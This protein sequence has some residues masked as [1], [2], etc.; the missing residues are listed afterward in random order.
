MQLQL[1]FDSSPESSSS[2]QRKTRAAAEYYGFSV[3]ATRFLYRLLRASDDSTVSLE[4]FDDVGVEDSSGNRTV[5]QDKAYHRDNPVANRAKPLWNTLSN[6]MEAVRCGHLTLGNTWFEIYTTKM[7]KGKIADS[8]SDA[9]TS[10]D[11]HIA[12]LKARDLLGSQ[13]PSGIKKYV[14]RFFSDENTA[15]QL[16]KAFHLVCDDGSPHAELETQW[17]KQLFVPTELRQDSLLHALGWVKK[18]IDVL[19]EKQQPAQITVQD[20]QA[21]MQSYIRKRDNRTIL[22]SI[23]AEPQS[24]VVREQIPRTYVCQLDLIG[25]DDEEKL[26]A[27]NDFLRASVDRTHWSKEGIIHSSSLDEMERELCSIWRN[28]KRKVE[29]T[30]RD[31][32]KVE[33]GRILYLDCT[34][35]RVDLEGLQ[36]QGH[37]TRGSLH[38]LSDDIK[39]GWHP[40]YKNELLQLRK[41]DRSE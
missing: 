11:A 2:F 17:K 34:R 5:E 30:R 25:C 24:G 28:M 15:C 40:D 32:T 35:Q 8:F 22:T 27:I 41:R 1:D 16:I 13:P 9:Q 14:A 7:W 33:Q 36:V 18:Q 26:E 21:E 3:Q 39:I 20:F 10:E 31:H 19:I 29:I 12:L 6:W 4:V 37:V 23:A 38:A